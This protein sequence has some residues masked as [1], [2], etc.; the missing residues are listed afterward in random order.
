MSAEDT[1]PL[2]SPEWV[3]RR[4]DQP[5]QVLIEVDDRPGLYH[6]GHLPG[7]RSVHLAGDLQ[8]AVHRDAPTPEAMVGLWQRLGITPSSTVIFYG[9]LHNW[10]AAYG[11]WLFTSYGL[12]DVRLLDGGRQAWLAEKLPLTQLV[13]GTP[14]N[15]SV[16]S[17]SFR[18]ERRAER[19]DAVQAAR[20]GLLLDVRSPEEYVGDWLTEP[21][22]SGE[23]AHRAGHI[24]GAR[25][26]PWDTVIDQRGRIKPVEE[27]RHIYA[28]AGLRPDTEVVTYCRI[29][30]RSAHTWFVLHELLGHR[31]VRN[32]DGSWTEWGS[33][34][35]MPIQLGPE[36]GTLPAGFTG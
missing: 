28:A 8:D 35:R 9:D 11:Y 24:P 21:E 12:P 3:A 5:D 32:Y 31:P 22:F 4:L 13:P 25:S 36:P 33:M 30:E 16:P 27:L 6:L 10:L 19:T 15:V 14:D 23:V 34:M 26:V 7:A 1:S 17:P 2:V 18:E 29:G 20:T